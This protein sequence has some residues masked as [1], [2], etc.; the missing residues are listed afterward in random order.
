MAKYPQTVEE[1]KK[2]LIILFEKNY[3]QLGE[4]VQEFDDLFPPEIL[5]GDEV[6][7]IP[8]DFYLPE[9][10]EILAAYKDSEQRYKLVGEVFGSSK[11]DV[12]VEWHQNLTQNGWQKLKVARP[13]PVELERSSR[14]GK[15]V[16]QDIDYSPHYCNQEGIHLAISAPINPSSSPYIWVSVNASVD[17]RGNPCDKN[18]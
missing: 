3:A 2:L 1:A 12:L 16:S 17:S 18:L 11:A 14:R 5:F 15:E 9:G 10:F 4:Y 7:S 13:S 8:I 6:K